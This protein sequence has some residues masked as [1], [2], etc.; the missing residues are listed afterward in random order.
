MRWRAGRLALLALGG[1]WLLSAY[2]HTHKAL[3]A[4]MQV[5]S[6]VCTV[7]AAD[8]QLLTDTTAADAYGQALVKQQI[9]EATLAAVRAAR[10]F[11][12]LDYERL[13]AADTAGVQRAL[14]AEL[15]D[16]LLE[17]RRELPQLAVLFITDPINE[18]YGHAPSPQFELLRAAGVTVVRVDLDALRDPNL[19]YSSLWRLLLRW[20]DR[21]GAPFGVA[22]RELNFKRDHRKVLIADDGHDGLTALLGSASPEDA[23]SAWSNAALR[24]GGGAAQVLLKSELAVAR[25]SG[26]RGDAQ[27]FAAPAAVG[28]DA[29]APAAP[30]AAQARVQVLTEGAFGRELIE[31]LEAAVSGD[32]VDAALFRLSDRDVIEALLGAARRGVRVRLILDPSEDATTLAPSGLPNQP[33][34]SELVARAAGAVHVRWYRTHGERFHSA[35]A[36]VYGPQRL[37]LTVGSADFTRRSLMNYNLE[38][39]VA[40]QLT[41]AAAPA[42]QALEY[43]ETLWSNR[44]AQGVEY[45][46][47]FAVFADPSQANYWLARLLEGAG[48]APF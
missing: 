9:F 15:T 41:P 35:F 10:R 1:A 17:R 18:R 45:S 6:P 12:V 29:A 8:V 7:P 38:A 36:L 32:A 3:P 37:W 26:W 43:F 24:F 30:S 28:C 13:A 5:A 34:A 48:L 46:A 19:L 23:Q 2:Y 31:Q 16:A 11:I 33:L 22:A 4:G 25:F 44:A 14:A 42:Q 20:W 39:N 21:P 47:D 40:L 27:P